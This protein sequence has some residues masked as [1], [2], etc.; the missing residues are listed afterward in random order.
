MVADME[1]VEQALPFEEYAKDTERLSELVGRLE[2]LYDKREKIIDHIIEYGTGIETEKAL[3][4]YSIPSWSCGRPRWRASGRSRTNTAT[5]AS[6]R[7]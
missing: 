2:H 5:R 4:M 7:T 3:R 6:G 1:A